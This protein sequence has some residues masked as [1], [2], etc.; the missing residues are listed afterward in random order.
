MPLQAYPPPNNDWWATHG[1]KPFTFILGPHQE[2]VT[3]PNWALQRLSPTLFW[4]MMNDPAF[5]SALARRLVL[6]DVDATAFKA[7]VDFAMTGTYTKTM[8]RSHLF[9]PL[10]T[11]PSYIDWADRSPWGRTAKPRGGQ[12]SECDSSELRCRL[13]GTTEDYQLHKCTAQPDAPHRADC[14]HCGTA[15]I[16]KAQPSKAY[17]CTKP[18]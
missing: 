18:C 1:R 12:C 2:E 6:P 3:V 4:H 9:A 7:L 14:L 13:C 10:V 5:S 17:T 8:E 16:S 11:R 15:K